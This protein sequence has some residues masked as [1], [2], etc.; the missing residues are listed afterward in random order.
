MRQKYDTL[1]AQTPDVRVNSILNYWTQKQVD[2]CSL[3][4]KAVR[5]NAQI[6]MAPLNFAP[7]QAERTISE[8]LTQIS[9]LTR[10]C[11]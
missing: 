6:A 11:G 7:E 1:H 5:D 8:C 10:I 4:K 9:T 3:G 2:F